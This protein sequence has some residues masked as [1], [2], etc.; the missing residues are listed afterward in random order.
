M[1]W[2]YV[3]VFPSPI[4]NPLPPPSPP[5]PCRLSQST[6]FG[7]TASHIELALVIKFH[8]YPLPWRGEGDG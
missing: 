4:L 8:F 2:P 7:H 5:H 3:Y 6:D 1:N